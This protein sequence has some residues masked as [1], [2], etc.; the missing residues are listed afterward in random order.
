M[1]KGV[2]VVNVVRVL[3]G[4]CCVQS[5]ERGFSIEISENGEKVLYSDV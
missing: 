4:E 2:I 5:G 3:Y 1:R